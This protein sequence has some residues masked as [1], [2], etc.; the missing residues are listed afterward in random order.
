MNIFPT[1]YADPIAILCYCL[2]RKMNGLT[3]LH[4]LMPCPL[5]LLGKRGVL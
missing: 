1:S 4:A 3:L 2:Y 5:E